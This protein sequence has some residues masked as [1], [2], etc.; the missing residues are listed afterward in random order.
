[1]AFPPRPV[2]G[3]VGPTGVHARGGLSAELFETIKMLTPDF[4]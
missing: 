4:I 3:A 1:M 2:N